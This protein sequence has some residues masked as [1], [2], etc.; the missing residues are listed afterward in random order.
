MKKSLLNIV[1]PLR[2]QLLLFPAIVNSLERKEFDFLPHLDRWMKEVEAILVNNSIPDCAEVAG[3]RSKI[4]APAFAHTHK[5]STRKQ[6]V[7]VAAG[8][9]YDVQNL[10]LNVLKPYEIKVGESRELISQLL[11]MVK[12]TGAVKYEN[13]DF[14]SFINTLWNLFC[15]HQQLK[16]G[17]AKLQTLLSSAD[18]M[19]LMA[20]EVEPSEWI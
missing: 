8:V 15:T 3:F 20:E 9:L 13:G 4:L 19:R 10:V 7:S 18:I 16:P 17:A 5:V 11:S 6:Q 2:A 1:I 14:Q 12:Q